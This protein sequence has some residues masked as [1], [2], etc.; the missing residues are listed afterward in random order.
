MSVI[1]AIYLPLL[2]SSPLALEYVDFIH[3]WTVGKILAWCNPTVGIRYLSSLIFLGWTCCPAH[4]QS[5]SSMPHYKHCSTYSCQVLQSSHIS[6]LTGSVVNQLVC[7]DIPREA[8]HV[9]NV[10]K[11]VLDH[12][13]EPNHQIANK[14]EPD[15][16]HWN[17]LDVI[18]TV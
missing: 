1:E 15:E 10:P 16:K 4:V 5:L 3:A 8:G 2:N 13:N 11:L 6:K 7:P 12:N 17:Y 18:S 9:D 14:S